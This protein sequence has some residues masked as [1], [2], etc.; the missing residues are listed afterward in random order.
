PGALARLGR[1]AAQAL[2]PLLDAEDT[3]A[4]YFALLT[5]GNLPYP[6]LVDGVLR[7]LFDL[8]PDISSA[9]RAAST[10]LKRVARFETAMKDL[11]Q[12]LTSNDAIRRS[13]AARALGVLH[14]REA[15]DGL[16][17]LTGSD[18]QMC[19]GAA[20]EALRDITKATFGTSPRQWT[21]WWAENRSKRRLEWLVA[22]LR[23]PELEIRISAIEELTRAFN[24]HLGFFPDGVSVERELAVRRWETLIHQRGRWERYDL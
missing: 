17:N 7:A 21:R 22:A 19:A 23:H 1:P 8:D 20:A 5:A 18:D 12:E 2:A 16:I 4:R 3:D 9:A 11:R 15:I 10:A 13:L 14:D 24:D 6:E